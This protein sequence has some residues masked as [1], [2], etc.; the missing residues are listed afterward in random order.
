MPKQLQQ[1]A[2]SAIVY[3][4]VASAAQDDV[5]AVTRQLDAC[6]AMANRLGATTEQVFIDHGTSGST[7]DRPGLNELFSYIASHEVQYVITSD[8]ARLGRPYALGYQVLL[9]LHQ[10]GCNLVLADLDATVEVKVGG[11]G[12]DCA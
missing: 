11:A 4:R 5:G 9:R 2:P 1:K 8:L 3:L 12:V 10:H 6:I 7:L